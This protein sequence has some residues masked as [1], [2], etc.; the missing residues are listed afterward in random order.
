MNRKMKIV[1]RL[2]MVIILLA[3]ESVVIYGCGNYIQLFKKHSS[4]KRVSKQVAIYIKNNGFHTDFILPYKSEIKDWSLNFHW[5][6]TQAKD[7]TCQFIQLGW[8]D[9][10]FFLETP[11]WDKLTASTV[12]TALMGLNPS[13]I[14]TKLLNNVTQNQRCV[15]V[16]ISEEQYKRLTAYIE[17]SIDKDD[18]GNSKP[19]NSK[20]I[21][22]YGTN[23]AFY[24]ANGHLS[25]IKTCNTW[26]NNGLSFAGMPS[27]LWTIQYEPIFNLYQS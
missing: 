25:F 18:Q 14:H 20:A 17:G 10:A 5:K 23:D 7:S 13:A 22:I 27:V 9:R 24:E 11:T 6:E 15:Q 21:A 19:I 1:S 26:I 12:V 2:T 4:A 3:L 16:L 8:G